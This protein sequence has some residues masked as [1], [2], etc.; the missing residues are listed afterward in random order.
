[1]ESYK[2]LVVEDDPLFLVVLERGI[3]KLGFQLLDV[4]DNS[5]DALAALGVK[6]PDFIIMD[7]SIRGQ[8]DGVELAKV[9]R[10]QV[11]IPILFLSAHQD[12]KIYDEV[13]SIQYAD[14]LLKPF[15]LTSLRRA[16]QRIMSE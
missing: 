1:M 5:E 16:I 4:V 6:T 2:V 8:L 9:I 14:Y 7:I 15:D 3:K 10:K 11:S 12:R 13:R